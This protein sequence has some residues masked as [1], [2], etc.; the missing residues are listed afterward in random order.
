MAHCHIA[1]HDDRVGRGDPAGSPRR[2]VSQGFKFSQPQPS[3]PTS[4]QRP[5]LPQR[6]STEPRRWSRSC[7]LNASASWTRRPP[8]QSVTI[9]VEHCRDRHGFSFHRVA[10]SGAALPGP[11]ARRGLRG[12]DANQLESQ[13]EARRCLRRPRVCSADRRSRQQNVSHNRRQ[14][15]DRAGDGARAGPPGR[16]R[17]RRRPVRTKDAVG[18]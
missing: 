15:R 1:E 11:L 14:H 9:T 17:V 12:T 13:C 2:A 6:T 8:L 18:D 5:P 10:G 7:S 3:I 16:S 4:R